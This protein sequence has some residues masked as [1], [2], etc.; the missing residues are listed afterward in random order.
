MKILIAEDDPVIG[1]AL[2]ERVSSLGHDS[3]GPATDGLKAVAAAKEDPPD[4]YLFD[5]DM[6]KLD[7]LAAAERLS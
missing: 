2:A 7:G 4:L 5:I 1:L 3:I 6:P